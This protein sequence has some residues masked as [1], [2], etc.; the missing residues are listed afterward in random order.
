MARTA[1]IS[2]LSLDTADG[3]LFRVSRGNVYQHALTGPTGR[4]YL[5][6]WSRRNP[7]YQLYLTLKD[8][9]V[10]Y[11]RNGALRLVSG[12]EPAF[13]QELDFDAVRTKRRTLLPGQPQP[14]TPRSAIAPFGQTQVARYWPDAQAVY[15]VDSPT[16]RNLV[17]MIAEARALE[18]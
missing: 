7:D 18:V 3:T 10:G 11:L 13:L 5:L 15:G 2:T 14:S 4:M 9:V 6:R 17:R 8:R 12:Q 16:G 1:N